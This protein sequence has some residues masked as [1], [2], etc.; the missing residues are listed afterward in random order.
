M[1]LYDG[2]HRGDEHRPLATPE[3]PR[4]DGNLPRTQVR[5]LDERYS[6]PFH[7]NQRGGCTS[8]G[9]F[10]G[11]PERGGGVHFCDRR[12][13]YVTGTVKD[14]RENEVIPTPQ[15]ESEPEQPHHAWLHHE[16]DNGNS[17]ND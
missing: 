1:T 10:R 5:G 17:E 15:H 9:G 4:R 13:L 3:Y 12:G 8:R 2:K 14:E 16:D 11:V 6:R 7:K